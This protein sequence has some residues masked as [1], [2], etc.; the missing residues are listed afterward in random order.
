LSKAEGILYR[1][2]PILGDGVAQLALV[3]FRQNAVPKARW[4]RRSGRGA[5]LGTVIWGLLYWGTDS[6]GQIEAQDGQRACCVAGEPFESRCCRLTAGVAFMLDVEAAV[7]EVS[8]LPP[9]DMRMAR[10][11]ERPLRGTGRG[12]CGA[13][14]TAK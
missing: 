14:E 10:F 7:A 4:W 8:G 5:G 9:M 12:G 2:Y 1:G 11:G 13:T 3:L 6:R